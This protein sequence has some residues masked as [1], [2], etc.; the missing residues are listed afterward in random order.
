MGPRQPSPLTDVGE[1][2]A[3]L[4]M[5]NVHIP[6]AISEELGALL[7]AAAEEVRADST[8]PARGAAPE[9]PPED[10]WTIHHPPI[11]VVFLGVDSLFLK[12]INKKKKSRVNLD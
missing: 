11:H 10:K 7:I 3:F 9:A 6:H 1:A 4:Q 12:K 8:E 5:V 2:I